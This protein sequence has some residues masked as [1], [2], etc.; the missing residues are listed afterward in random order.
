MV[1]RHPLHSSRL[2]H[3]RRRSRLPILGFRL[4]LVGRHLLRR[5]RLRRS[6]RRNRLPVL[7][8]HL[9][10]VGRRSP[11][12]LLTSGLCQLALL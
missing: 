2:Q 11:Q 1:G 7:G 9:T 6:F 12:S 5:S 4:V 10:T 8:L 3:P